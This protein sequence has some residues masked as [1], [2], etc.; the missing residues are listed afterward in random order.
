M[1]NPKSIHGAYK[2]RY[3]E[4]QGNPDFESLTSAHAEL[5][6]LLWS[7]AQIP[8]QPAYRN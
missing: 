2:T 5:R 6:S 4:T 1:K 7:Q 3:H 8:C